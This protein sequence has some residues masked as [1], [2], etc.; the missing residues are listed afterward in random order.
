MALSSSLLCLAMIVHNESSGEPYVG[1]AAVAH[2][3]INRAKATNSNICKVVYAPAQFYTKKIKNTKSKDWE[4]SKKIAG[5]ILSRK[6]KDPTRGA[7]F[8]HNHSVKPKWSKVKR[9]TAR[10]GNHTFYK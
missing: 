8:F 4:E 5:K 3:V 7:I 10:I 2:V 1:K 6:I 9:K